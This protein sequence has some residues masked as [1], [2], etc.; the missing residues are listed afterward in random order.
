[1]TIAKGLTLALAAIAQP[2]QVIRRTVA[3]VSLYQNTKEKQN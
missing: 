3:G 2:V 1:M